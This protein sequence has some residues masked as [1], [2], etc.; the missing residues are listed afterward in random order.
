V[1]SQQI[2]TA[3]RAGDGTAAPALRL[4]GKVE[5]IANLAIFLA[6]EEAGHITGE[7][8]VCRGAGG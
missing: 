5:D 8:F 6:S 1:R 4:P 3:E 2:L 7:M